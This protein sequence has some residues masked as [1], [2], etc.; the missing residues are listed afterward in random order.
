MATILL[1]VL[2]RV[3][4]LALAATYFGLNPLIVVPMTF[5]LS[6]WYATHMLVG[7]G[8]FAAVAGWSFY[9]S[10]A[11]RPVFKESLLKD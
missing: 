1:T 10:L 11:G 9:I 8:A 4:I 3:G 6:S 2:F 5:R 7:L